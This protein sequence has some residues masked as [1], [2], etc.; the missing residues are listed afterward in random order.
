MQARL[1]LRVAAS[2]AL[3]AG[4]GGVALAQAPAAATQDWSQTVTK[5]PGPGELST[6]QAE[7]VQKLTAYF[8]E[9]GDSLGDFTQTSPDG[10][11]LR[12]KIAIKRPNLFR[13]EYSRPSRQVIISDGTNMIIQDLDLKTDDRWG[14]DK[15]PF[16]IVLRKDVDLARDAKILEVGETEDRYFVTLRD[17]DP[18]TEGKL[19]LVFLKA[20]A[21]ELKE[22]VTTDSQG[23]D[24]T[25]DLTAF[26]RA[27]KLD[28]A[29][30]VP[31]NLALEK[32]KH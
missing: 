12:G 15:T 3:S 9:M 19:K 2:I 23:Q 29:L 20:P 18:R 31:V 6:A 13:F 16:R 14:L 21:I 26:T 17:K 4:V 25:V 10:K 24:T 7:I 22:W 27:E 1:F 5:E 30:F 8:N 11:R 28:P 32:M